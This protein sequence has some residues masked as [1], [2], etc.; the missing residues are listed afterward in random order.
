MNRH[1]IPK[2]IIISVFAVLLAV[3]AWK[4]YERHAAPAPQ[5]IQAIAQKS[6]QADSI[7]D[8]IALVSSPETIVSAER[9]SGRLFW[10]RQKT[11]EQS[12]KNSFVET[13]RSWSVDLAAGKT[14]LLSELTFGYPGAVVSS[15]DGGEGSFFIVTWD[16]GWEDAFS[17]RTDYIDR[18]TG[19]LAYTLRS[20]N[21]LM[22]TAAHAGKELRIQL[23]PENGCATKENAIVTGLL[24]GD[25]VVQLP[26]PQ[27]VECVQND[28]LGTSAY[29]PFTDFSYV[30]SEK[31]I[32]VGFPWQGSFEIP[33]ETFGAKE[34]RFIPE[35]FNP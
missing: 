11:V 26:N 31:V 24:V 14:T 20:E 9:I 23:A 2:V 30:E 28:M 10:V 27:R 33:A 3:T 22:L 7:A 19:A 6:P 5:P 34:G 12:E 25:E 32:R 18:G 15:T 8:A 16:S 1:P 29:P 17:K 13:D 21:D 35:G 4:F